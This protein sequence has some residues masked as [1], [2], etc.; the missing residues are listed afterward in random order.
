MQNSEQK[1]RARFGWRDL[2]SS[3]TGLAI[4]LMSLVLVVFVVLPL[5]SGGGLRRLLLEILLTAVL[6]S[7]AIAVFASGPVRLTLASLGVATMALSWI[8]LLWSHPLLDRIGLIGITV[9][10]AGVFVGLLQR[11]FREGP[12]GRNRIFGAVAAYLTLGLVFTFVFHLV[13]LST[14]GSFTEGV[15]P[16]PTVV[17]SP[18]RL[19][20]DLLYFSF[21]TLTTL[22]YGDI[23]PTWE[24][25][26]S[27][28]ILEALLG[29]LFI[30]TVLARLVALGMVREN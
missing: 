10:L 9:F 7:G 28:A 2:M 18:S 15:A 25:P 19:D 1:R 30:A 21:V 24:L 20:G 22:G 5:G 16:P 11:V 17:V 27:L 4:L 26:R 23:N 14:P 13:E 6:I 12:V 3:E 29:Q 8:Q